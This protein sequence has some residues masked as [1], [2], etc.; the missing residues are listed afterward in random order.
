MSLLCF[1]AGSFLVMRSQRCLKRF[2]RVYRRLESCEWQSPLRCM[3]MYVYTN[4]CQHLKT[5]VRIVFSEIQK[6]SL[7]RFDHSQK[8]TSIFNNTHPRAY[9]FLVHFLL[10]PHLWHTSTWY[11]FVC[12]AGTWA[13]MHSMR[14]HQMPSVASN[15]QEIGQP[16]KFYKAFSLCWCGAHLQNYQS[17]SSDCLLE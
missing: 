17:V 4:E 12:H 1:L 5:S 2:L 11:K 13:S 6:N 14:F 8:P 9:S 16:C 15:F 3:Y 10:A 7:T